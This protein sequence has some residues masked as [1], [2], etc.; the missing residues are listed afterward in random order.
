VCYQFADCL[1]TATIT[2]VYKLVHF[3]IL[4]LGVLSIS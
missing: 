4:P 3:G 2:I 1:G